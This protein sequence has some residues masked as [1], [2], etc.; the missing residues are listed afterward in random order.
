MEAASFFGSEHP[1][2]RCINAASLISCENLTPQIS[3]VCPEGGDPI[4]AFMSI[5]LL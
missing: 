4:R 1:A 2:L 5:P 3:D